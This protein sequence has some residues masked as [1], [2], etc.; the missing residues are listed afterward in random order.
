MW[1]VWVH[2]TRSGSP[3]LRLP[4]SAGTW[5]RRLGSKGNGSHSVPLFNSGIAKSLV[6]EISRGNKYTLAQRWGTHCAYAG[7]IQSRSFAEPGSMLTIEHREIRAALFGARLLHGVNEYNPASGV[8]NVVGQTHAGAVRVVLNAA[9]KN[10][11]VPG[12]ELPID[13]PG[14]GAGSFSASWRHEEGLTVENT[15]T[16]IEE[17]GAETDFRPYLD[18]DG[19]L[20]YAAPVASPIVTGAPYTLP[21]RAPGS[22]VS[23]LSTT[24]DYSTQMTGVLGFGNGSGQDRK[25]AFAPTSGDGIRDLPVKD[26]ATDF[27]DIYDQTRLQRAL[28]ADFALRNYPIEQW[29]FS[30]YVGGLGPE[31]TAPGRLLDLHSFG[32][33][34][35]PDGV[36]PHRVVALA[37]NMTASVKPEVQAYG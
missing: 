20:R 2:N 19:Y 29:S 28:N 31:V 34:F 18:S 17:D 10:G 15:L 24:D 36:Y 5:T 14:A 13:L 35:I 22:I 7:V 37:G 21:T 1:E 23:D 16:Q 12:W 11:G 3:E 6:R 8:V 33:D 30:L 26:V 25:W 4:V 27:P 32:S 9:T